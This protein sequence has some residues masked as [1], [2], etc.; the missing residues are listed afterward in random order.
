MVYT[1]KNQNSTLKVNPLGAQILSWQVDSQNVLHSVSNPKRSG[2]PLMFPY[3]GPLKNGI[4]NVSQKEMDQHGFGRNTHW[5][6]KSQTNNSITFGHNTTDLALDVVEAFPYDFEAQYNIQLQ[7]NGIEI[8]LVTINLGVDKMP[9][10]PGFHPYFHIPH[11]LKSKLKIRSLTASPFDFH[12]EILPWDTGLE[13]QFN[14]NPVEFEANIPGNGVFKFTDL[15][16][17]GLDNKKTKLPCD[18]LTVWAGEVGDFVCI[19]P[20]SK[21]FNSINTD[22]I[23]VNPGEHYSLKYS[24]QKSK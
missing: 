5:N 6:L 23:W 10:C 17:I 3:C 4:L 7:P 19:E 14:I 8:S 11:D 24:I 18:L 20:M 9:I 21:R 1:L 2:I 22:P 16:S 12:S 13:A 15:C